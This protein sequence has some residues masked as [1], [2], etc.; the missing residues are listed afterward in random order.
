MPSV[1]RN[2]PDP[3]R[4]A[5]LDERVL[6]AVEK[7]LA[8]GQGYTSISVQRIIDEAGVA[9]ST[10]YAH[11]EDKTDVL[12]RLAGNLRQSLLEIVGYWQ[13]DDGVDGLAAM[14]LA[15]L[16][17]HREH[18]A[19]LAAITET[20][21]YDDGIRDFFSADLGAF[22]ERVAQLLSAEQAAGRVGSGLA[23]GAMSRLIVWGGE[24]AI[25]HHIRVDDGSGDQAFAGELAAA[26]WYGAFRRPA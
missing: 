16:T 18:F 5:A 26:W 24:S 23:V 2:R 21:A 12:A 19:V 15:S 14:F 1:T 6:A 25:A 3:Q 22:E 10:F 13:P 4:R 20:A 8:T 9:R 11:F 17:F 7:L